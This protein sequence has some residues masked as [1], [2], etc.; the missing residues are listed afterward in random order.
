M[1]KK[2]VSFSIDKDIADNLSKINYYRSILT[3]E[4]LKL[5]FEKA[6]INILKSFENKE[7]IMSYVRKIMKFSGNIQ[8]EEKENKGFDRY[9]D[10]F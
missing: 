6:D 5:F 7:E 9:S 4:L 1:N 2:I 3:N 10:L 8:K